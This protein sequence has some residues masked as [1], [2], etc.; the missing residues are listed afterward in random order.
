MLSSPSRQYQNKQDRASDYVTE[1]EGQVIKMR[2]D[3][4]IMSITL[5]HLQDELNLKSDLIRRQQS[6]MSELRTMLLEMQ[7][8]NQRLRGNQAAKYTTNNH[9]YE[10]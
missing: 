1:L 6:E 7:S 5:K 8:E 3:N 10:R 2:T 9:T 4:E